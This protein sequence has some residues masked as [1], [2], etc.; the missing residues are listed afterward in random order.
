MD[1]RIICIIFLCAQFIGR[2]KDVSSTREMPHSSVENIEAKL[3]ALCL[4]SK[5]DSMTFSM[6]VTCD[7]YINDYS[8]RYLG[9]LQVNKKCFEVLQKTVLSGQNKESLRASVFIRIFSKGKLYGEYAGLNNYYSIKISAKT[10]SIFNAGTNCYR[11][12]E[13]KDSLPQ[14]LFFPYNNDDLSRGD[15]FYF[16]RY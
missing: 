11:K 3:E 4:N 6:K 10:I 1:F 5:N 15:L 12:Y 16:N 13:I 8:Y 2:K 9:L 7:S 14:Q